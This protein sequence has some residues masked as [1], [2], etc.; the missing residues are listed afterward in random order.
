MGA[1]SIHNDLLG[2]SPS[3]EPGAIRLVR[4]LL[5]VAANTAVDAPNNLFTGFSIVK[6]AREACDEIQ[7]NLEGIDGLDDDAQSSDETAWEIFDKNVGDILELE[8]S[9]AISL[10]S[11]SHN[12]SRRLLK[13]DLLASNH[14]SIQEVESVADYLLEIPKWA[15]DR[16]RLEQELKHLHDILKGLTKSA[17]SRVRSFFRPIIRLKIQS[18]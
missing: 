16:D 7:K 1:F 17:D 4:L 3:M 11:F 13:S 10:I 15:A 8:R 12:P 5:Q 9:V 6:T 14:K 18:T 2:D